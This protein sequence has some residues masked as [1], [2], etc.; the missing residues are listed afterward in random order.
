M[1]RTITRRYTVELA[2]TVD[3]TVGPTGAFD[4]AV[5]TLFSILPPSPQSQYP[6]LG[7]RVQGIGVFGSHQSR[8][9]LGAPSSP[10]RPRLVL[11]N[12]SSAGAATERPLGGA[13]GCRTGSRSFAA[14]KA[15]G[16]APGSQERP[17]RGRVGPGGAERS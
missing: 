10:L 13:F 2:E 9:G 17:L 14:A 8:L 6:K 11:D 12:A 4:P 1:N 3:P 16:E 7:C 15:L 5:K